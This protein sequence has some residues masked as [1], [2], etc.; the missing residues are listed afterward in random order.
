MKQF[1]KCTRGYCPPMLTN[2][3]SLCCQEIRQFMAVLE[4]DSWKTCIRRAQRFWI[5]VIIYERHRI[6]TGSS[7]K[8]LPESN[9]YVYLYHIKN[10]NSR[11][12]KA[13]DHNSLFF[14]YVSNVMRILDMGVLV[15]NG[16]YH[17]KIVRYVT[18]CEIQSFGLFV[19]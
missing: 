3:E 8:N 12:A 7:I 13:K 2:G 11:H 14:L 15:F 17:E 10:F 1:F 6:S 5:C 19:Y 4:D 16:L 18:R 9:Q